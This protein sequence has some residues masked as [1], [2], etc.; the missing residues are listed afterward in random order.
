MNNLENKQDIVYMWENKGS[1]FTKMTKEQYLMAGEKD[2]END[3]YIKISARADGGPHSRVCARET[4]C[5]APH[6]H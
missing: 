2:L 3:C 4:L 5:S 6:R 1:S